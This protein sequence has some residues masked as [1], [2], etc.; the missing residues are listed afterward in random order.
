LIGENVF[1]VQNG[2]VVGAVV[3]TCKGTKPVSV[4]VGHMVSLSTAVEIVK[5][6][7]RVSR[8]PEPIQLAHRLATEKRKAKN[9]VDANIV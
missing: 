7:S 1:L 3:I 8:V 2:E 4:S 5:H 9:A 6:C